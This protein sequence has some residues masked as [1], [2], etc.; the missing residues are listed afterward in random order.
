MDP[1]QQQQGGFLTSK[2]LGLP[3]IV[4]LGLVAV[5]AY[6]L[7]SNGSLGGG[8]GGSTSGGGGTAT[9]SGT[10]SLQRGAVQIRVT[11]AIPR[12][13]PEHNPQPK[14]PVHKKMVTHQNM[15]VKSLRSTGRYDVQHIAMGHGVTEKELLK[16]NPGLR[17]YAGSNK[18]VPKGTYIKFP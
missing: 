1:D 17:K 15:D 2:F 6:F 13:G 18:P 9:S 3:M 16:M 14:P 5:G 8:G 10:T 7:I 11:Q 12:H 4:W